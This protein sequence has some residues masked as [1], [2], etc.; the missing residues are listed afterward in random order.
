MI[1]SRLS[2]KRYLKEVRRSND[3][4]YTEELLNSLNNCDSVKFWKTWKSKLDSVHHSPHVI[5]GFTC[6]TDIMNHFKEI[7]KSGNVPNDEHLHRAASSNFQTLF[8]AMSVTNNDICIDISNI[9]SA[10]NSI[11]P[12][13]SPGFDMITREHIAYARPI[14][15]SYIK[16][17]F[18]IMIKIGY[19]P[20]AFGVGILIPL[21]KG[22]DLDSSNSTNYGGITEHCVF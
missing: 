18:Y 9:E 14:L 8:N 15:L 13:K 3:K 20:D 10:I 7:F 12:G 2:Y 19:V 1:K 6:T 21:L 16:L 5:D 11:K 17:L 4:V 22:S